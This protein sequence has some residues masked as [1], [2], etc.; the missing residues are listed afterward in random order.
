MNGRIGPAWGIAALIVS[1]GLVLA[2]GCGKQAPPT[3]AEAQ[4]SQSSEPESVATAQRTTPPVAAISAE[5]ADAEMLAVPQPDKGTPEWMLREIAG[6][7]TEMN[8]SARGESGTT[9]VETDSQL[10]A[11][12]QKIIQLAR[13]V[14]AATHQD[15]SKGQVFNNAVHYLSDA[16]LELAMQG[17]TEQAELLVEDAE[18]LYRRDP[19]SF[20]AVESASKVVDLAQR[21]VEKQGKQNPEWCTEYANQA[22]LFAEKFPHEPNRSALMLLTAGQICDRLGLDDD[23]RRCFAVVRDEFPDTIFAEQ[24]NGFLRRFSLVGQPLELAGPTID[25][26]YV[27]IDQY[28]GQAVLVVFWT[29]QSPQFRQDLEQLQEIEQQFGQQGLSVIGVNLDQDEGSIDDF[30]AE[31]ALTWPQI[32]YSEPEKRGGRNPVA[33]FYGVQTIPTYWLVDASGNV[34]AMPKDLSSLSAEIHALARK[35]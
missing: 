5:P 31:Q 15:E 6:I 8:A 29:S 12:H 4:P 23:A 28:R 10:I 3:S 17:D 11:Q 21:K 24:V 26:G 7:R 22:R 2:S 27:S 32:F 19:K 25:G 35:D 18:S 30:L 13:Q 20:A 14:I 34:A 16:R 9:P 1:W 33:R